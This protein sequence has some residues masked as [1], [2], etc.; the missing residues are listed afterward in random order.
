MVTSTL[1]GK[2]SADVIIGLSS[3]IKPLSIES[4]FAKSSKSVRQSKETVTFFI[5]HLLAQ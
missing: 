1:K 5:I 4:A 2:L 3:N